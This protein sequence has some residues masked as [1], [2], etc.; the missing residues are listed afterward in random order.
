MGGPTNVIK[1][2]L[3]VVD[4]EG[5]SPFG[6]NHAEIESGYF[7][8][9]LGYDHEMQVGSVNQRKFSD[10]HHTSVNAAN[11]A[12]DFYGTEGRFEIYR[13][14]KKILHVYWNIPPPK[15]FLREV[16]AG[17]PP[18]IKISKSA[19]GPPAWSMPESY[20][21]VSVEGLEPVLIVDGNGGTRWDTT[22][23]G[24][25]TLRIK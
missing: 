24:T 14:G 25:I 17:D 2:K 1:I 4:S 3:R 12:G 20:E 23:S 15:G 6:I 9:E 7:F 5:K 13:G 8:T 21:L 18:N 10:G 19:A 22:Y 11:R 16:D